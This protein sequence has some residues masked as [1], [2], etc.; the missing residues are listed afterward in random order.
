MRRPTDPEIVRRILEAISDGRNRGDKIESLVIRCITTFGI[1]RTTVY[2]YCR[3][4]SKRTKT[5]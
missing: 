4:D 2:K 5:N 1:S 3:N